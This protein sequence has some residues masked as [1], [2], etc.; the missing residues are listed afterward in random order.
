MTKTKIL[1]RVL[2]NYFS[3][4]RLGVDACGYRGVTGLLNEKKLLSAKIVTFYKTSVLLS[5]T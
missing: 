1:R 4:M 2:L 3:E 5:A